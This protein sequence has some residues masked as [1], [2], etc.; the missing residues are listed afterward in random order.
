MLYHFLSCTEQ[1][2]QDLFEGL[3]IKEAG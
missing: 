3:K 2:E 1:H